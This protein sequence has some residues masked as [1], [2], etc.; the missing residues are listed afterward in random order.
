MWEVRSLRWPDV[1]VLRGLLRFAPRERVVD[2]GSMVAVRVAHGT[3][4][5][6]SI[7]HGRQF[8]E[9]LA[10]LDSGN[11]RGDGL[12]GATDFRGGVRLQIK[13]VQVRGSTEQVHE[14]ARACPARCSRRERIVSSSGE[15]HAWQQQ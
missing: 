9:M 5:R 10:N 2:H 14:D 6:I 4:Q 12:K 1:V 3:H 15:W 7:R 13:H 11:V 8:W